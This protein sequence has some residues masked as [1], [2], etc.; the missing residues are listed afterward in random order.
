METYLLKPVTI[1]YWPLSTQATLAPF[2]GTISPPTDIGLEVA[3]AVASDAMEAVALL[4]SKMR[5]FPSLQ[6]EARYRPQLLHSA[7]NN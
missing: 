6:T 7:L 4:G 5:I 3:G 1:K 2:L